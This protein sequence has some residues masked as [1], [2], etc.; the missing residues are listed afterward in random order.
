M[1]YSREVEEKLNSIFIEYT[2]IDFNA[3][4]V[5]KEAHLLSRELNVETR[6]L[7][8]ILEV[9]TREFGIRIPDEFLKKGDFSSFNKIL[10]VVNEC[11]HQEYSR[12][13]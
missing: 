1:P 8:V 12:K 13:A 11:V 10:K 2:G 6:D 5:H 4:P 3:V 9:I 7:V